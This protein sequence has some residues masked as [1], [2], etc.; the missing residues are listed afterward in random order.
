MTYLY[1]LNLETNSSNEDTIF[2]KHQLTYVFDRFFSRL[3]LPPLIYS[4]FQIYFAEKAVIWFFISHEWKNLES[5][6]ICE[7]LKNLSNALP[8]EESNLKQTL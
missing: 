8:K 5:Q 6:E 4:H 2:K 3:W 1:Q 7:K